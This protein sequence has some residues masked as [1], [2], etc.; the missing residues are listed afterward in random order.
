MNFHHFLI[1]RKKIIHHNQQKNKKTENVKQQFIRKLCL[2]VVLVSQIT[3]N[4]AKYFQLKII[5]KLLFEHHEDLLSKY[6]EK[7]I[8]DIPN[9]TGF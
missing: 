6:F 4:S 1:S 7:Y 3:F 8:F 9:M 5:C 2:A